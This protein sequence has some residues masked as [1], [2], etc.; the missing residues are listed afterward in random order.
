MCRWHYVIAGSSAPILPIWNLFSPNQ[1]EIGSTGEQIV[2]VGRPELL[3]QS[4]LSFRYRLSIIYQRS[5]NVSEQDCNFYWSKVWIQLTP[6]LMCAIYSTAVPLSKLWHLT[7]LSVASPSNSYS[8]K[9]DSKLKKKSRR[10]FQTKSP[11]QSFHFDLLQA[12]FRIKAG[13]R[14]QNM[15]WDGLFHWKKKAL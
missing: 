10:H 2:M 4:L 15:L 14:G 1:L 9:S 12:T 13:D 7:V 6:K 11:R 8:R 5:L 3:S